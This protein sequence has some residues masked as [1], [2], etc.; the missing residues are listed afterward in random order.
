MNK[1]RLVVRRDAMEMRSMELRVFVN[2]PKASA[3]TACD[4]NPHFAGAFHFFG[5][6]MEMEAVERPGESSFD[7]EIDVSESLREVAADTDELTLTL[8]PVAADGKPVR[9][10]EV[11]ARGLELILD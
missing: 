10:C 11:K 7:I 6:G 3:R 1:A 5:M 2:Q 8:V 4:D 9:S